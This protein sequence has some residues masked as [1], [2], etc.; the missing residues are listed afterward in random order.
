[1]IEG[2]FAGSANLCI[3]CQEASTKPCVVL[4]G[5]FRSMSVEPTVGNDERLRSIVSSTLEKAFDEDCA[6]LKNMPKPYQTNL[7]F[8]PLCIVNNLADVMQ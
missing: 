4:A 7:H 1:M 2:Q 8:I 6:Y 3:M 5:E